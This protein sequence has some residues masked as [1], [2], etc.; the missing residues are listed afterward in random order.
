M[1]LIF[2]DVRFHF[3]LFI[4]QFTLLL[5]LNDQKQKNYTLDIKFIHRHFHIILLRKKNL[6]MD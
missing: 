6:Y 5:T 1:I 3:I 4:L 2:N